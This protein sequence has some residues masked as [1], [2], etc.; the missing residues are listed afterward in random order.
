MAMGSR[1]NNMLYSLSVTCTGRW[2]FPGTPVSSANKTDGHEITEI[3]SVKVGVKHL[4]PISV[5]F[6]LI[7]HSVAFTLVITI[8]D[9]CDVKKS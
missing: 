7:L 5:N 8:R 6:H 9:S 4:N 3:L 2:F 1:Y